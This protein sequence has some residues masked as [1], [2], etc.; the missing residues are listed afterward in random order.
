M[1]NADECTKTN[2]DE[3]TMVDQVGWEPVRHILPERVCHSQPVCVYRRV[4]L[5][6]RVIDQVTKAAIAGAVVEI[7]EL[8]EK[9]TSRADGSFFFVGVPDG[10]YQLEASAPHLG[11]RYGQFSKSE[12]H[13]PCKWVGDVVLPP[14]RISGTVTFENGTTLHK[15]RRTAVGAGTT[16]RDSISNRVVRAKVRLRGDTRVVLTDTEGYYELTHLVASEPT[17]EVSAAGFKTGCVSL[18]KLNAGEDR[19]VN[20]KLQKTGKE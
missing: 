6:G 20:V 14:T 17:V 9:T 19:R 7:V 8:R 12:L 13:V 10:T 18:E 1:T 3:C 4:A 16:P 15:A 5:A 2:A 11:T